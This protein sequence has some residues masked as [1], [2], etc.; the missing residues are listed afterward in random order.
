M[1]SVASVPARAPLRVLLPEVCEPGQ[2][3]LLNNP[4]RWAQY[5]SML[6]LYRLISYVSSGEGPMQGRG[7]PRVRP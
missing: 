5:L 3:K 2:E 4:V 1:G 7:K 6:P